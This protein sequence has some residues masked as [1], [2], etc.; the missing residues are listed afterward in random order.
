MTNKHWSVNSRKEKGKKGE[1]I[2]NLTFCLD[3]LLTLYL[4]NGDSSNSGMIGR[5][6]LSCAKV[7]C[8][9]F[10]DVVKN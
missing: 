3:L 10:Y 6:A 7:S 8:V 5:M 4:T 2:V 1:V 9:S